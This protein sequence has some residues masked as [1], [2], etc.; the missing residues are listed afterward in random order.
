MFAQDSVLQILL[1]LPPASLQA[2]ELMKL[3]PPAPGQFY[4]DTQ[5]IEES[6]LIVAT[7][8]LMDYSQRCQATAAKVRELGPRPITSLSLLEYSL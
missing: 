2:V 1:E 7:L 5:A 4:P 6:T 8:E 3:H